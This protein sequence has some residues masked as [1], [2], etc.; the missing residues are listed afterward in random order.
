MD[1]KGCMKRRRAMKGFMIAAA[2][3][4]AFVLLMFCGTGYAKIS[5]PYVTYYGLAKNGATAL[6]SG[7]VSLSIEGSATPIVSYALGSDPNAG[8]NFILKVPMDDV[9]P[10][11][12]DTA[13][14]GDRGAIFIDGVLSMVLIIPQKGTVVNLDANKTFATDSD[15]DGMPDLWELMYFGDLSRDGNGDINGNGISDRD[16]YGRGNDPAACVWRQT[17]ETHLDACVFHPLV[18]K[19]CLYEAGADLFDNNINLV[20]GTYKGS[21]AYEA[22][23]GEDFDLRLSGGYDAGCTARTQDAGLTRVDADS[24]GDG[25]GDGAGLVLSSLADTN[26]KMVVENIHIVNG[27]SSSAGG[28]MAVLND[29]GTVEI[30]GNR[31]SGS[32]AREGGGIYI[33]TAAG[34]VYLAN[35]T[36]FGN[37]SEEGGGLRAVLGAARMTAVNNT[38]TGN[39]AATSAGGASVSVNDPSAV[40]DFSSNILYGNSAPSASDLFMERGGF[41]NP[42]IAASN[43]IGSA[44]IINPSFSPDATNINA[45]PL[46]M[47]SAQG[48]YHLRTGS[49]C[50]DM[51]DGGHQLLPSVDFEGDVRT[52]GQGAD[53]GSD[54]YVENQLTA[55]VSEYGSVSSTPSGIDGCTNSTCSSAFSKEISVL[56]TGTPD[57]GSILSGWSGCD[58]ANGPDCVVSMTRQ[59]SV[60]VLFEDV[61][62]PET[63]ITDA[64]P[65]ANPSYLN[66]IAFSF[67]SS[68]A[69][70][71]FG[72]RMDAGQFA[73]CTSPAS[74]SGLSDGVHTFEVAATDR[75]GNTDPTP[76]AYSW[77]VDTTAPTGGITINGGDPYTTGASVTLGLPASDAY[78][79]AEMQ[80][81]NDGA[82][83][84]APEAYSA[85]RAWTL[86]AGDGSKT[87]YVKYGD[88]A[89]NWSGAY[90]DDILL[91]GLAPSTSASPSGSQFK[92]SIHVALNCADGGSGCDKTYWCTGAGCTP[93]RE[94][95][96]SPLRISSSSALRFY[97]KDS[98]GNFEQVTGPENY[99]ETGQMARNSQYV[100]PEG[101]IVLAYAEGTGPYLVSLLVVDSAGVPVPARDI[102][103]LAENPTLVTDSALG[104]DVTLALDDSLN[105]AYVF[106][107]GQTGTVTSRYPGITYNRPEI[108]LTPAALAFGEVGIRKGVELGIM[109]WN[110]G[111]VDLIIY[112]VAQPEQPFSF[113]GNSCTGATIPPGNICT[114]SVRFSPSSPGWFEGGL[115]INSNGG[116][117][118]V[119]LSG[120]GVR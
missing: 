83:W 49:P 8:Q 60:S 96:G 28:G 5:E 58:T 112:S 3:F 114:I 40:A 29:T 51:G 72:C 85:Q 2:A 106:H 27:V 78:G 7:T 16:E 47:D 75:A 55:A 12:P 18:L 101:W 67:T 113:A 74:Y 39:S 120:T 87:V 25:T 32:T 66:A 30:V 10:R 54:E 76:S 79:V 108:S 64:N 56:L 70:S 23:W 42:V 20:A 50:I 61:T 88:V 33:S 46:F 1:I 98:A 91:D 103:G 36:L 41:A 57:A 80:L 115:V 14:A 26:G 52:Y 38:I 24:D 65:N 37:A 107:T 22:A 63:Q 94:Y 117:P 81:S 71:T 118:E 34:D 82:S 90:S 111:N 9:D 45:D 119:R 97:S 44:E 77:T 92:S 53:I 95:G 31:I 110:V 73:P 86:I 19:N 109:V 116:S 104:P 6:S 84:T 62:P 21:F 15:G 59:R 100:S 13:R 17:D 35:N 68:E 89:G 48:N 4:S 11:T 105:I 99:V 102:F 43:D 69:G 93:D